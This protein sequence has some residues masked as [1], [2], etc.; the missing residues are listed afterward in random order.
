MTARADPAVG[1]V[2]GDDVILSAQVL[3]NSLKRNINSWSVGDS[4]CVDY[5]KDN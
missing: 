3:I 5:L 1:K 2:S 4:H